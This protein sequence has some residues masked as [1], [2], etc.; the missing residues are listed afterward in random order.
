MSDA[1]RM[2]AFTF[3]VDRVTAEV[4]TALEEASIPS[5]VL[6]GP[7]IAT[8]LYSRDR[9]RLYNDSDLLLRRKD[10]DRALALVKELG[11]EDDLGPLAH[12]RMESGAGYPFKRHSDGH[13][14]DL[15]YILFGIGVEPEALW[16]ALSKD[17]VRE[18]VGGRDVLLPSRPARLMHIALHAV[19]HGGETWEKPMMDLGKAIEKAPLDTWEKSLTLA[20]RLEA[21]ETFAAGLRLTADGRE[22][23]KAIGAEREENVDTALRLEWVPMAEG[24]QELSEASGFRRRASIV[25]REIFPTR[26]F[27]RWWSPMARRGTGSLILAYI[28]RVTWLAYRAVPGYLAWRRA[29]RGAAGRSS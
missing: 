24:F 14:V 4:T 25:A 17:G 15:H 16:E 18:N 7:G 8:W 20:E 29:S 1:L 5:I 12:P 13:Q 19:Q 21:S 9:P 22:L 10:W 23:A 6:K 2:A 3:S 11:F 27:M 26:A 28:W